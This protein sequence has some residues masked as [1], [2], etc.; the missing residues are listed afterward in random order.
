MYP[1]DTLCQCVMGS[2]GVARKMVMEIHDSVSGGAA[3]SAGDG[4]AGGETAAGECL[5]AGSNT[6]FTNSDGQEWQKMGSL[7]H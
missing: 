7:D 5:G 3:T 6:V 4:Y 1:V 2:G